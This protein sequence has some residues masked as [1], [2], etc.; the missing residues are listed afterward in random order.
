M[1]RN[2]MVHRNAGE[3][4]M[5]AVLQLDDE[6]FHKL[7]ALLGLQQIDRPL[8][9]KA[10]GGRGHPLL[11]SALAAQAGAGTRRTHALARTARSAAGEIASRA[12]GLEAAADFSAGHA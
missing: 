10:H 9:V 6:V 2:L 4:T 3:S 11:R 5:E 1:A 8:A 12:A 7:G